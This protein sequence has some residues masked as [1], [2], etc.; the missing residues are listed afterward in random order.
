MQLSKPKLLL[1][2]NKV[3]VRMEV[4]YNQIFDIDGFCLT[5]RE[6]IKHIDP[7]NVFRNKTK[8]ESIISQNL[9]SKQTSQEYFY[10]Q[11][12]AGYFNNAKSLSPILY[13]TSQ[14]LPVRK[15]CELN[16]EDQNP[17]TCAMIFLFSRDP[18]SYDNLRIKDKKI[19]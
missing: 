18:E 13:M 5:E 9:E 1:H 19:Y 11:Y 7:R 14:F 6:N 12:N 16:H 17:S 15:Y 8:K 2:D 4:L 10:D 3:K